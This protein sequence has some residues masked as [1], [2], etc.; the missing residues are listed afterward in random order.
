ALTDCSSDP[1]AGSSVPGDPCDL[2]QNAATDDAGAC[3]SALYTACRA[4]PDCVS[5]SACEDNCP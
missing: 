5:Y 4:V 2:C 1:D 3:A